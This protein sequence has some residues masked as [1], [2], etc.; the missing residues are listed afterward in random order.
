M[1]ARR[2][3]IR[4]QQAGR[5]HDRVL[6]FFILP[7][8]GAVSQYGRTP[9]AQTHSAAPPMNLEVHIEWGAE[10]HLFGRIHSSP[11]SPDVSF[12]YATE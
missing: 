5:S 7:V 3:W 4:P 2:A 8:K 9:P 1:L 12:E 6:P 11:R 10:T